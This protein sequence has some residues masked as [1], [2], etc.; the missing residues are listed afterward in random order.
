LFRSDVSPDCPP[1][2]LFCLLPGGDRRS[3]W[4]D[5][6]L[7]DERSRLA[8]LLDHSDES[9]SEA[10]ARRPRDDLME[11]GWLRAGFGDWSGLWHAAPEGWSPM[12]GHGHQDCGGFELHFER[13]VVFIDPGRGSYALAGEAEETVTARVHNGLSVDG[14]DPYPAN[15]PYY[16]PSFRRKVAGEPPRLERDADGVRLS[17][18][19]FC[20]LGT[21]GRVE[22]HW[23]F[24]G[25]RLILTDRVEGRGAHAVTRRL[26][27]TGQVEVLAE[28]VRLTMP[29]GRRFTVTAPGAAISVLPVESWIAYGESRPARRVEL[30]LTAG[31]PWSGRITVEAG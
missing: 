12:P 6:L 9:C 27:T 7:P 4:M 8:V 5:I 2:Y 16:A 26:H 11:D 22:R 14:L 28:G 1:E 15:K 20:R 19:G 3:G 25:R 10:S 29:G 24:E 31:L 30:T 21:V 17:F 13:E 18:D 23:H